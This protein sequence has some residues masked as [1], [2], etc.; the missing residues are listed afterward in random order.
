MKLGQLIEYSMRNTLSK[1]HTE[2]VVEKLFADPF[3]KNKN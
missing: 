2:N 1:N 3:I